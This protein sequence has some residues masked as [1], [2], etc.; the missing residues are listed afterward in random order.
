MPNDLG[1][2][3]THLYLDLSFQTPAAL[4]RD[5]RQVLPP[6]LGDEDGPRAPGPPQRHGPA[7]PGRPRVPRVRRLPG[8]ASLPGVP[9]HLSDSAAAAGV[10]PA[11]RVGRGA[12]IPSRVQGDR[13]G[14]Q[15][16]P[17]LL[18]R[19]AARVRLILRSAS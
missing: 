8:R 13:T 1:N 18:L 4:P 10:G 3:E 11:R 14:H 12:M 7:L 5:P 6:V 17:A 16:W 2:S 15:A 9:H 19:P